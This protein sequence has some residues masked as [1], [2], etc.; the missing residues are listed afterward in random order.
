MPVNFLAS[1][2]AKLIGLALILLCLLALF[3]WGHHVG[4]AG[5]QARWDAAKAVQ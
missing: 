4:A 5:V 2:Y 1:I 3:L